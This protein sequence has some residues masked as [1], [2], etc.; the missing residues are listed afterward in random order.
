MK[1]TVD[2]ES[3]AGWKYRVFH[4][5]KLNR[6]CFPAIIQKFTVAMLLNDFAGIFQEA[7]EDGILNWIVCTFIFTW[8]KWFTE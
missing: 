4:G 7:S 2:G 3:F 5:F 1:H 6:E 8:W